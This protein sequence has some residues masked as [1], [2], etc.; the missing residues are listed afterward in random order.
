M[1]AISKQLG[2]LTFAVGAILGSNAMAATLDD[3][4]QSKTLRIAYREDA[5]PFAYKTP[6]GQP[7]GYMIDLC[8]ATAK[9]LAQQLKIPDLKV[10]YVPVTTANRLDAITQNK[11]DLLCDS[12][13]QT[14]ERRM[15]VDFSVPNFID[16]TSLAIS[17]DGPQDLILLAGKKV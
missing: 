13:T 3:I 15:V 4:R 17:N 1:N 10:A 16:G 7:A 11:A 6:A 12:L 5:P 14:V 2:I 8:Q 9:A